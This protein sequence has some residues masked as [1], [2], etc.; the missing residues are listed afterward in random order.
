MCQKILKL[1]GSRLLFNDL[2]NRSGT[3]LSFVLPLF[4]RKLSAPALINL[5]VLDSA[6]SEG[7]SQRS[8]SRGS[9]RGRLQQVAPEIEDY[10]TSDNIGF[11]VTRQLKTP[12]VCRCLVVD[13][14]SLNVKIMIRHILSAYRQHPDL[15]VE[16]SYAP[17][18]NGEKQSVVKV[19]MEIVEADDGTSALSRL[20]EAS[21]EGRPFDAVFMDNIMNRMNGPEAA[22]AMR[23]TGYDGLIIGVTGNVMAKDVN[24]YLSCGA[25]H[26]LFKPVN[27][28]ELTRILRR[29]RAT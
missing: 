11:I 20:Q 23:A 6:V 25:D 15:F 5:D 8:L 16:K 10:S 26:I 7:H 24:H 19:E 18:R 12:A 29:L 13:D 1:H 22:Q 2:E 21:E 3:K 9:T 28:E 27:L 4:K 17:I 14:S